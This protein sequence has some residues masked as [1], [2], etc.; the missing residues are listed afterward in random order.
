LRGCSR[1]AEEDRHQE[2]REEQVASF[3]HDS[4]T[5]QVP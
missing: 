2:H 3:Q 5:R 4:L 1:S